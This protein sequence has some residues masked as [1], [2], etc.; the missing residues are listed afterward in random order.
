MKEQVHLAA[1]YLATANKSFVVPKSDDSHTNLGFDPEKGTLKTHPL[2]Q[3]GTFLV[4]NY[5]D[6]SLEW[7]STS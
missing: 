4:F 6:F 7:E 1:Q 2:S 3:N 5:Q